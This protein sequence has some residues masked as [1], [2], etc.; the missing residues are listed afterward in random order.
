[1]QRSRQIAQ[2]EFMIHFTTKVKINHH[3]SLIKIQLTVGFSLSQH[4]RE[5]DSFTNYTKNKQCKIWKKKTRQIAPFNF[6]PLSPLVYGKIFT[7]EFYPQLCLRVFFSAALYGQIAPLRRW[8]L[9]RHVTIS[10]TIGTKLVV[11]YNNSLLSLLNRTIF[12]GAV[13][14]SGHLYTSSRTI[15]WR[16]MNLISPRPRYKLH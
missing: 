2:T 6:F 12:P 4:S 9:S 3:S 10:I 1:M 15:R 5:E 7:G 8:S 11:S 16:T 14:Q 13:F